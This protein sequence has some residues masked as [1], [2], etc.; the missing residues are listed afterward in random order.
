M[1]P[2][3]FA[4]K[5]P[6]CSKSPTFKTPDMLYGTRVRFLLQISTRKNEKPEARS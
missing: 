2:R 1:N 3:L 4:L 6:Q 5:T